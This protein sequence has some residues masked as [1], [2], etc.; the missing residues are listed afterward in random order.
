MT[1]SVQYR[2]EVPAALADDAGRHFRDYVYR[3][4]FG[5]PIA[6]AGVVDVAGCLL[7]VS[8]GGWTPATVSLCLLMTLALG[9]FG[10]NYF[11]RPRVI[12]GHLQRTFGAGATFTLRP[13]GFDVEV[14]PNKMT[15][16]WGRQ[17]AIVEQEGYF[18]VVIAPTIGLVLPRL[19]MPEAGVEWVRAAMQGPMTRSRFPGT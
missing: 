9:Y 18:L 19:G 12:S 13:D 6:L 15:R 8:F 2:A 14:G 1:D 4:M 11:T 10:A 3:R 7:C 16:A 17:R 5:W